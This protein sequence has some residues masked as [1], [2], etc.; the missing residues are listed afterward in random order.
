MCMIYDRNGICNVDTLDMN[1]V[2]QQ[3]V[4]MYKYVDG[5]WDREAAEVVWNW[6]C[7]PRKTLPEVVK[8]TSRIEKYVY[9]VFLYVS[10]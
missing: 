10:I 7:R 1:V 3:M 2:F 6:P 4:T 8:N 5:G 9:F